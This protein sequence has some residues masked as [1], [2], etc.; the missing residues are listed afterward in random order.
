[1]TGNRRSHRAPGPSAWRRTIRY[2]VMRSVV[3]LLVRA[4]VRCR[5][6]GRDRLPA[7]P[8]L[9]CFNHLGW[10][11]PFILMATMP[12]RPRLSFFGPREDDMSV[13]G[14]NRLMTWTGSAV[15]YRPGREDLLEAT[16][17]AVAVFS[18]GGILAIAG[19]GRI[20]A[21]ERTLLPLEPGP[22][23]FALRA[24]VPVVPI[25]INGASWLGFGRI[26]RVRIGDPLPPAGR[27]TKAAVAALTERTW[28][29]LHALLADASEPRPSHGFGR[30]L[31]ELYND[32][33]DGEGP[34][35]EDHAADEPD[36][37]QR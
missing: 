13:G 27:P 9:Y 3:W 16:R 29:A 1:M 31:T 18:S 34:N 10:T 11:D 6:E 26:I 32:W 23:Y 21:G 4:Y 25:A 2:W 19:E 37:G 20:H 28:S 24:G 5:V 7:G 14:R 33:P 12:F 22:A 15:P 35:T 36:Q 17:R 8:A 30:W